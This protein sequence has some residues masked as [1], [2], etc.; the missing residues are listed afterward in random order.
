MA[1]L[2][3]HLPLIA[4]VLLGVI[5]GSNFIYMKLAAQ[6]I[7]PGQIVFYRVLFGFMPILIYAIVTKSLRLSHLRHSIHFFVMSL[8]ATTVYYFGF[9]KGASLLLSGL[10]GA[11]SGSIP[12]FSFV[13]AICFI[14]EEKAVFLKV[15]GIIVGFVGVAMIANPSS[16]GVQSSNFLGVLYMVGGSLSVGASFVYAKKFLTPLKIPALALTTYQLGFAMLLLILF[17]DYTDITNVF[18]DT[19]ATLGLII[20]LGILGTGLAY[21]IY[22]FL[23]ARMGAVTAS[24]VTYIPPLVALFIGS[25][26]VGEPIGIKDYLA[27]VLIFLGVFLLRKR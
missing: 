17:T 15:V 14:A 8:L 10:A 4:F 25:I 7:T 20:G 18:T 22:Y 5:W 12:L 9:A 26:I 23:V 21:M 13:L 2:K 6:L 16:E 19:H 3:K 24:S 11:L 1:D 27:T